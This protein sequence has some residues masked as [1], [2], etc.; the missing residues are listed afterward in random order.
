MLKSTLAD[1]LLRMGLYYSIRDIVT[2]WKQNYPMT[3]SINR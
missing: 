2:S 3:G 1:T